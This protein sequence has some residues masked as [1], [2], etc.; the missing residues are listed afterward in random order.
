MRW[1]MANGKWKMWRCA[2]GRVFPFSIF[3]FPFS[4][5]HRRQ[6]NGVAL[7][8][9]VA[10]ILLATVLGFAMLSGSMLQMRA[11]GNLSKSAQA[12]YLAESG[13]NL[14]MYYLQNPT[15]APSLNASGYWAG[16]GGDVTIDSSISGTVNVTVTQDSSNQWVYEVSSTGK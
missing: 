14:A 6:R 4:I 2:D 5:P 11:G 13:L 12:D 10:L 3:H 15:L 8:M 7:V 16:T 9:V 1:Q